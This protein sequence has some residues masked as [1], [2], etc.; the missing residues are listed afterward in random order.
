M[1]LG[2]GW[3]KKIKGYFWDL[4]IYPQYWDVKTKESHGNNLW[5]NLSH[6]C[7]CEIWKKICNQNLKIQGHYNPLHQWELINLEDDSYVQRLLTIAMIDMTI[8]ETYECNI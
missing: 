2:D 6:T 8:E 1:G 5:K 7:T 4:E 3:L